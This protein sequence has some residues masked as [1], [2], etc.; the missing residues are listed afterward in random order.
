MSNYDLFELIK[1]GL[2]ALNADGLF[3]DDVDCC[4]LLEDECPCGEPSRTCVAA[5]R[6]PCETCDNK[7]C[8]ND[9]CLKPMRREHEKG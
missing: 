3:N 7:R 1:R 9:Y 2:E 5:E 8:D 6:I 4:C